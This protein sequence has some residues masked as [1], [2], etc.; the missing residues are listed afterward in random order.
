MKNFPLLLSC[1]L[2][3]AC[4][5]V[6]VIE[7]KENAALAPKSAPAVLFVRSF[8]VPAGAEFDVSP[9][10]GETN[11]RSSVSRTIAEGILSRGSRWVAPTK[12]LD[13]AKKTPRKGLL[14][15][16]K[17]LLARQGSRAL[18]IGIGFGA[19]R[20]RL[21]TSVRV[22]NLEASGKKP[23][24]AFK[25][26][27]GSNMEPGLITSIVVP[28]PATIPVLAGI[29]GGAVSGVTKS[30]KG[31]S[32]DAKRTGRAVVAEI[33]DRLVAH[34]LVKRM[35]WPKRIGSVGTPVG[36]LNVP[37]LD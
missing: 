27:G 29:A 4:S 25:T 8:E 28:S 32:Q 36:E 37:S 6:S 22:F 15:D 31:V 3:A 30:N 13:D 21:D 12:V 24:L 10:R 11:A 34:G 23:W 26:T 35:A 5:S 7:E 1:L 33:H 20:T 16:G 18:R 14:I 9:P 19:G 17:V 2:L